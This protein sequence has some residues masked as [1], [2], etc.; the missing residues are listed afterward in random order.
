MFSAAS[1]IAFYSVIVL[2]GCLIGAYLK[3]MVA[4]NTLA[5]TGIVVS[6]VLYE[7]FKDQMY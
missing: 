7:K 3:S 5:I 6:N 2:I 1:A 4:F